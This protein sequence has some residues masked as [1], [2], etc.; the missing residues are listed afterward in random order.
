MSPKSAFLACLSAAAIPA[1]ALEISGFVINKIFQ[2]IPLAQV[3]LRS[4]PSRC[5]LTTVNGTFSINDAG[6]SVPASGGKPSFALELQGSRLFLT[7]PRGEKARIDWHDASGRALAPAQSVHLAPGRNALALPELTRDGLHFV[8]VVLP[9]FTLTWK[10][11]LL[12]GEGRVS[13]AEPASGKTRGRPVAAL[14]KSAAVLTDLIVNKSGFRTSTYSP[15]QETE[16]DALVVLTALSDS[17]FWF[18]STYTSKITLDTPRSRWITEDTLRECNG[19]IPVK[20]VIADTSLYAIRDGLLYQYYPGACLGNALTGTST[21]VVGTWNLSVAGIY[22]PADLRPATCRDTILSISVPETVREAITITETQQVYQASTEE[23]PPDYYLDLIAT[24]LLTDTSVSIVRNTCRS[25][26]FE[27]G[28]GAVASLTFTQRG[29]SLAGVF[30]SGTSTCQAVHMMRDGD[31]VPI[32][33]I[34]QDPMLQFLNCVSKT[35]YFGMPPSPPPLAKLAHPGTRSPA[36][37]LFNASSRKVLER[38]GFRFY[39]QSLDFHQPARTADGPFK[40]KERHASRQPFVQ[41]GAN[42][43]SRGSLANIGQ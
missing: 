18:T 8:R 1:G 23:C 39:R 30:T 40:D 7:A 36:S 38:G 5:A 24:Y 33:C 21:D 43:G 11:L 34:S 2:P 32:D 29:D 35:A 6:V 4:V 41:H 16:T 13:A 10:A 17:G 22:L 19:P 27:N 25:V 37:D 42:S 20:T 12:G 26:G 28:T 15:S 9:G 31:G 3:C 14:S